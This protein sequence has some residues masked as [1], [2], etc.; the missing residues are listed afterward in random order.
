MPP[1]FYIVA[2]APGTGKSRAFPVSDFGVDFFNADDRAAEL[3]IF[4]NTRFGE[5]P[6]PVC[7]VGYR[8][9][10]ELAQPLPGWVEQILRETDFRYP[11][12]SSWE[13]E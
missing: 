2:G 7:E 9:I 1:E 6:V 11:P 5:S 10:R 8:V 12:Q 4:D 3:I 13:G